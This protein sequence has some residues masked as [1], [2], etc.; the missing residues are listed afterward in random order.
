[1][2]LEFKVVERFTVYEKVFNEFLAKFYP[3]IFH[4]NILEYIKHSNSF[5]SKFQVKKLVY[6]QYNYDKHSIHKL[7]LWC[8]TVIQE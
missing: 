6:I 4:W 5:M 8:L 1:M 3:G 2:V 7:I